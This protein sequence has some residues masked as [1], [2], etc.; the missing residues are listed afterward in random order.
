MNK[1]KD[2]SKESIKSGRTLI[3]ET[4]RLARLK[5]CTAIQ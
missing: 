5:D 1:T 3:S 2:K 4:E